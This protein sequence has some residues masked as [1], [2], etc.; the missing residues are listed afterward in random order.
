M[1]PGDRTSFGLFSSAT[2]T[3]AAIA[4]MRYERPAVSPVTAETLTSASRRGRYSSCP[5]ATWVV[6]GP[7]GMAF[8]IFNR[9]FPL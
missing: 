8:F 1:M 6:L 9:L 7:S 5:L 3:F 4:E 2:T